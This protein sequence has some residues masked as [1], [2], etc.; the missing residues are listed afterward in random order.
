MRNP[1]TPNIRA[2]M[3]TPSLDPASVPPGGCIGIDPG[4]ASG[5]VAYAL[6]TFAAAWPIADMTDP[7]LWALVSTLAGHARGALLERVGPMPKQGVSSTFKFGKNYG[8]LGMA[9]AASRVRWRLVAPVE[10]QR[11]C[12][13]LTRGDKR[14]SRAR[15]QQVFPGPRPKV[16]AITADALLIAHHAQMVYP[17]PQIDHDAAMRALLG[18][19]PAE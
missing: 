6:G 2:N 18:G 15:A 3:K 5:C 8:A 10:W 1:E 12:S 17:E 19:L 14:V 11:A 7:E 4:S 9:L 13:C 16:T